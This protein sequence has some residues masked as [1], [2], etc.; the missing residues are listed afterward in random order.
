MKYQQLVCRCRWQLFDSL[1]AALQFYDV[2]GELGVVDGGLSLEFALRPP[3]SQI[4]S[5]V[6]EDLI[7]VGEDLIEGR[8]KA[9]ALDGR[10]VRDRPS[11][12]GANPNNL[13]AIPALEASSCGLNDGLTAMTSV[14]SLDDRCCRRWRQQTMFGGRHNSQMKLELSR[15]RLRRP[16]AERQDRRRFRRR[17][18]A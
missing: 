5:D 8:E 1:S 9:Q 6:G 18:D 17:L 7:E 13:R 2:V 10:N 16:K 14:A 4:V 12:G 3:I 15:R 11:M